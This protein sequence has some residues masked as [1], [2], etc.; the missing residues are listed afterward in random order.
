MENSLW[1]KEI[2]KQDAEQSRDPDSFERLEH[3]LLI[4]VFA[5]CGIAGLIALVLLMISVSS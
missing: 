1:S 5:L 2:I 3:V 4:T